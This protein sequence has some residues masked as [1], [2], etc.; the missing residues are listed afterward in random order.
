MA[1][2]ATGSSRHQRIHFKYTCVIF[3]KKKIHLLHQQQR[4]QQINMLAAIAAACY[5]YNPV[6]F[7]FRSLRFVRRCDWQIEFHHKSRF[8][9][10]CC[11]CRLLHMRKHTHTLTNNARKQVVA[12]GALAIF[13][14]SKEFERAKLSLFMTKFESFFT[15]NTIFLRYHMNISLVF[16]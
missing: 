6:F 10:C 5:W 9:F 14:H 2:A 8:I 16:H 4:L 13:F 1:S 3:E 15:H 12:I 11:C 7:F